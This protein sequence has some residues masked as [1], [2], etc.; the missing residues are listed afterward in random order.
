MKTQSISIEQHV[1]R[2][3]EEIYIRLT[4]VIMGKM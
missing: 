4:R 1:V 3:N 2:C